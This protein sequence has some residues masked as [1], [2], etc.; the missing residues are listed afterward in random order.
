VGGD[1]ERV[2]QNVQGNL[3]RLTQR[4]LMVQVEDLSEAMQWQVVGVPHAWV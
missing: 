2:L 1:A 3:S 4:I